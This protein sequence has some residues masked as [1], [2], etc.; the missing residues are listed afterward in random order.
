MDKNK[1]L[2]IREQ[3]LARKLAGKEEEPINPSWAYR[4]VMTG[5]KKPYNF[6]KAKTRRKIAKA[7]RKINRRK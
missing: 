1:L 7:S 4:V 5:S 3:S 6:K 2:F